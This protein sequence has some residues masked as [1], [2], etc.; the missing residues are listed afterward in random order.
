M[1]CL[2]YY[3]KQNVGDDLFQTVIPTLFPN[4]NF[5]FADELIG[6]DYS[7]FD[8][9]WFGGGDILENIFLGLQS[10]PSQ[11]PIGFL[12]VGCGPVVNPAWKGLLERAKF[13][14]F[15]DQRGLLAYPKSDLMP[16]LVFANTP[17][18]HNFRSP[19]RYALI[20]LNGNLCP[21]RSD[22]QWKSKSWDWFV[23]EFSQFCDMLAASDRQIIFAAMQTSQWIDDRRAAAEV[24]NRMYH[25][26]KVTWLTQPETVLTLMPKIQNAECVVSARLHGAILATQVGT[27]FVQLM[28]HEKM[29]AYCDS[30]SWPHR[31]ELFGA[32]KEELWTRYNNARVSATVQLLDYSLKARNQWTDFA[33]TVAS[34]FFG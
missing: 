19:D 29:K 20:L 16:D 12:G 11:M 33:G 17:F 32:R 5:S 24:I 22:A 7:K 13:R 27:P 26:T 23:Y 14:V 31:A 30:I 6:T 28:A 34:K 10:I 2:G 1:L 3:G 21:G 8:G 9:I 15:R 4:I 18:P 25:M